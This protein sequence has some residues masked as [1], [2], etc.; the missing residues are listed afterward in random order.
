MLCQ[1]LTLPSYPLSVE[2]VLEFLLYVSWNAA[3][4]KDKAR[5]RQA[6]SLFTDQIEE[7]FK[8]RKIAPVSGYK[9]T[10]DELQYFNVHFDIG[11]LPEHIVPLH[12]LSA[13][14][15]AFLT[16]NKNLTSDFM[17]NAALPDESDFVQHMRWVVRKRIVEANVKDMMAELLK[18]VMSKKFLV[19]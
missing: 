4:P 16:E 15:A 19:K 2:E 7:P 8:R 17:R 18:Q 14:A 5:A 6:L 3:D 1:C 11:H 9:W 12:P 10:G 13:R